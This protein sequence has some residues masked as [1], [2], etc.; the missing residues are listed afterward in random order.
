LDLG[1]FPI[2]LLSGNKD[3]PL[4]FKGVH[5]AV[6]EGLALQQ[7]TEGKEEAKAVSRNQG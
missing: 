7:L 3:F 4:C 5:A 2:Q 6:S 1:K